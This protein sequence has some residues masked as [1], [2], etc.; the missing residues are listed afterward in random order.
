[1][2][3]PIIR[4]AEVYRF[5]R[6]RNHIEEFLVEIPNLLEDLISYGEIS[7]FSFPL[8]F[9]DDFNKG[10]DFYI[11][12]LGI[13]IAIQITDQKEN[14]EIFERRGIRVVFIPEKDNNGYELFEQ[15]KKLIFLAQIRRI[16]K[17]Y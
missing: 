8:C 7:G 11:Y 13:K 1:M 14:I 6:L 16:I 10:I 17:K 3:Y 9:G 2:K 4:I 15:E 12:F 5:P